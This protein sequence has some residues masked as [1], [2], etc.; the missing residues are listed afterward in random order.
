M[1]PSCI[2]VV[3][4]VTPLNWFSEFKFLVVPLI[5]RSVNYTGRYTQLVV[6]V[7]IWYWRCGNVDID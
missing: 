7:S 5:F 2:V 6:V 1:I 3:I 4:L